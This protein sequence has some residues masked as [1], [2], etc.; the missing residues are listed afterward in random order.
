ML[1]VDGQSCY[2]NTRLKDCHTSV[3]SELS[4]DPI[5]MSGVSEMRKFL[6]T[7][8]KFVETETIRCYEEMCKTI[9]LLS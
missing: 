8:V 6:G 3:R 9:N 1:F 4:H 5:H 7:T 2:S